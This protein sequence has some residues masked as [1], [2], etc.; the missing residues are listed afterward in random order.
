MNT[1]PLFFN[2]KNR[3]VLIIGGGEVAI[4]KATLMKSAGA[5]I[6]VIAKTIDDELTH[7]LK[8]DNHQLIIKSYD[9]ADLNS[10][11]AFCIVATDDNE[12]NR[13]IYQDC[14]ILNI[15]VNVVD[16]P[17]LC[18]FIF[19]AIVDRDPITIG[20]SSNGNSP[21]LAR[22]LRA[23]IESI[24]PPHIG[25]LAQVAGQ[26][27]QTIKER[28]PNVNARR[29]FWEKIFGE[30]LNGV[31]VFANSQNIN[32]DEL[33]KALSNFEKTNHNQGEVYIVGAG[34]GSPDLLTFKA[35]RLMQQAD[36][37]LYDA[38]VS[39][40]ILEL[41]RRDS[42]K[43]FVGKKRSCHAKSQDEINQMLVDLAKSGKRVLRLKGGDPFIFGRGGEE[44]IAC[45]RAG[46]PY[47]IVSGITASLAGASG[48]G[49]PLTHRGVAT[50]V[51]FLTGCYQ[52]GDNF[53]GLK[54]TYQADETLVFYMGLHALENIVASLM[55]DLPSDTPVAIVSNASLP[56]QRVLVG[57]LGNIV[58]KQKIANL[59]A[60]AI[61]IVGRV[62]GLYQNESSD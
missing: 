2:L 30:N 42:D 18:D 40:E 52:T 31:G 19:P 41:C 1:L 57:N 34:A 38:L 43:I 13:Q 17:E 22:L 15:P 44:M 26:F 7:L 56:T 60:P 29:K 4:R 21:V 45:Q 12:L 27:R 47:Q 16:T 54:S 59:S 20:I 61:I 48:A 11:F 51:R 46:V 10:E 50:S 3:C 39:D 6:T 9:K 23:K 35:L 58:Q 5:N 25:K 24:L 8:D 14:K 36:V 53:D 62:V 49:I 37:V 28:L 33:Q 32:L 55:T